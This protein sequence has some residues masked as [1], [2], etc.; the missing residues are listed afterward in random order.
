M[1]SFNSHNIIFSCQDLIYKIWA[2]SDIDQKGQFL[3][4]RAPKISPPPIQFLV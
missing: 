3:K 1:L 2:A 4:K